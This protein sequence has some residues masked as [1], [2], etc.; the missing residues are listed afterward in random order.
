MVRR[1]A[2]LLVLAV[3][4]CAPTTTTQAPPEQPTARAEPEPARTQPRRPPPAFVQA[5]AELER[6]P[7]LCLRL[8]GPRA[9]PV[10]KAMLRAARG[11]I[12]EARIVAETDPVEPVARSVEFRFFV[13]STEPASGVGLHTIHAYMPQ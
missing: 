3:L 5:L 12:D 8:V 10:R 4:G 9:E 2:L 13:P 6:N 7:N 1:A 11:R